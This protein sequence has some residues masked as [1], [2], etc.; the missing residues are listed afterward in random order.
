M[1]LTIKTFIDC[2]AYSQATITAP[3]P[4]ANPMYVLALGVRY[5]S[6]SS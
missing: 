2:G 3:I 4:A 1:P 5:T 6:I